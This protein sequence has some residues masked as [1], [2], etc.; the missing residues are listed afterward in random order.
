MKKEKRNILVIDVGGTH[1]KVLATGQK[2]PVKIPSGPGMTAKEMARKVLDATA[3]WDYSCVSIG[4]PGPVAHGRPMSEPR[5]LG[6]GWVGFDFEKAFRRPVKVINDAAM[7]ALG[8]YHGGQMLFLGLGTGMGS[9]LI[10]DGVLESME[11]G[12]LP[13]KKGRTYE[14]YVGLHGLKRLGKKKWRKHVKDVVEKLINALQVEY[15]VLGGGNSKLLKK[16]PRHAQL[17]GNAMAYAG[18]FRLWKK[19]AL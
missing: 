15:V 12:H 7:Q 19:G 5:N 17:G 11:L 9:A 2:E 6:A 1:V 14:D 8:S 13:Y 3:G 4:Y 18:G 16:L 10:V